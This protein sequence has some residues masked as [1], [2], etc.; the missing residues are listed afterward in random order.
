MSAHIRAL[1]PPSPG[2]D[3]IVV[4]PHAGGSPRSYASW[5]RHLPAGID[6]YGV[7]YPGRDAL[8]GQPAPESLTDLA[9]MCADELHVIAESARSIV[10]FGHSMGS[11]VAFEAIRSLQ[12]AKTPVAALVASGS[13]APHTRAGGTWHL[14]TDAELVDHMGELDARNRDVFAIPELRELF[15]PAVR[16]DFRL[17]ERYR[18]D[19]DTRVSCPLHVAYG[20]SDREL[21]GAD[22]A[23]WA[24]HTDA[25]GQLRVFPGD[26]FYLFGHEERIVAWLTGL[27]G[28]AGG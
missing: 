16:S 14:A 27:A 8:L 11:Y 22:A 15:L 5:S 1:S 12:H 9:T 23:A 28:L 26:H 2:S 7:T 10:I 18:A 19:R 6:L 3:A 4:F 25:G 20:E 24:A 21:A 17:V 13:K